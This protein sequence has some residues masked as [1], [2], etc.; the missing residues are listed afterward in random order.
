MQDGDNLSKIAS[1]FGIS[2]N[3]IIWANGLSKNSSLKEGSELIIL[4]VSGVIYEAKPGDT[5]ESISAS[6]GI[7]ESTIIKTNDIENPNEIMPGAKL[8]IPNGKPLRS[9]SAIAKESQNN[10]PSLAGFFAYPVPSN[11]LNWGV[12]HSSNA[13][14][15][16]NVCGTKITAS[17]SG[18]VTKVGNPSLWN[19]GYGGYVVLE[20]QNGTETL[21]A[22]TLENLVEIGGYVEKGDTIAKIG[23]TGKATGCHVHFEVHGARNPFTK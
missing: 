18:M 14:D 8:I 4:P 16:A 7:S 17:A 3:T 2:L 13:V 20:H 6:F 19:G 15:F 9:L 23:K 1:Q 22:H 10:L 5:I 21:Y 11:S 12:L